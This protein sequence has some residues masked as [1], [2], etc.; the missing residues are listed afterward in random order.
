MTSPIKSAYLARSISHAGTLQETRALPT[1]KSV[2]AALDQLNCSKA[3]GIKAYAPFQLALWISGL[4]DPDKLIADSKEASLSSKVNSFVQKVN[5]R[6]ALTGKLAP[7]IFESL[8]NTQKRAIRMLLVIPDEKTECSIHIA[9]PLEED[10]IPALPARV[11]L[12]KEP[13]P[14]ANLPPSKPTPAK[15]ASKPKLNAKRRQPDGSTV[16]SLETVDDVQSFA[17]Q[18]IARLISL[19]H[20]PILKA[21]T[22]GKFD[23]MIHIAATIISDTKDEQEYADEIKRSAVHQG[24]ESKGP[25][26]SSMDF[27][28][29]ENDDVCIPSPTDEEDNREDEPQSGS[30]QSVVG[31]HSPQTEKN[32]TNQKSNSPPRAIPSPLSSQPNSPNNGC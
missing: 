11:T 28:W 1:D 18:L 22:K 13:C 14:W 4:S 19:R 8:T 21:S 3:R 25:A 12:H 2:D 7:C 16:E 31:N 24:P 5:E 23:Q 32:I 27:N 17:S 15:K 6:R 10:L 9:V 30:P 29:D 20:K 26:N